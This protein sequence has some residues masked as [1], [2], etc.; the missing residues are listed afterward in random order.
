MNHDTYERGP[1]LLAVFGFG[2][3]VLIA[4]TCVVLSLAFWL[5]KRPGVLLVV[6]LI[7]GC[8]ECRVNIQHKTLFNE[9][10]LCM[11]IVR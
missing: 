4:F 5:F 6:F 1:K 11:E 7:A 2:V 9:V 3:I 10:S 8:S